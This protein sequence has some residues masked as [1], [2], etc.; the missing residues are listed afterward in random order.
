[1]HSAVSWAKALKSTKYKEDQNPPQPAPLSAPPACSHDPVMQ[2]IFNVQPN[3]SCCL[4]QFRESQPCLKHTNNTKSQPHC[5]PATSWVLSCRERPKIKCLQRR[6]SPCSESQ[7]KTWQLESFW[8][9]SIGLE[10]SS[11]VDIHVGLLLCWYM[12]SFNDVNS[13]HLHVWNTS[14]CNDTMSSNALQ[15]CTQF[16]KQYNGLNIKPASLPDD[17]TLGNRGRSRVCQPIAT[18]LERFLDFM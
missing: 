6:P 2:S 15:W 4:L 1:M 11:G 10:M 3:I 18:R 7:L 16:R 17:G 8:L 13:S 14:L 12:K 5:H 9:L